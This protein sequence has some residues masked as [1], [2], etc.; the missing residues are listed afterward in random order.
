MLEES[1]SEA[2][3]RLGMF[4]G[5]FAAMA[6]WE[7]AN[8]RRKLSESKL[9]R[10]IVNL[11]IICFNMVFVRVTVGAIAFAVAIF[12]RENGWGLFNYFEVQPWIAALAS[13]VILDFAIYLQHIV[14]HAVP[15]LWRLHRVHH[16]DLDFDVTTGL[17]FHPLEIMLSLF[18]KSIVVIALGAPP[19]AVVVFEIILNAASQFNHGNV[20]IPEVIDRWLRRIIVTPDMHRIHHSTVVNETNSN[21]GFSVSWWDRLC[22]T[23]KKA[24]SRGHLKMELGLDEFRSQNELGILNLIALPFRGRMGQYSFQKERL[25]W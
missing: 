15:I 21:F 25:T 1:W 8:P 11:G 24:P 7:A 17:R 23:Y 2:A 16:A 9:R 3:L 20:N 19:L 5:V 6:L 10:W 22:G 18:Y 4:L 12:A 14:V 13:V